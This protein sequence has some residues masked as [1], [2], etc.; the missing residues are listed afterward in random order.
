M[1]SDQSVL[2]QQLTLPGTPLMARVQPRQVTWPNVPAGAQ[3]PG[4]TGVSFRRSGGGPRTRTPVDA[5]RITF[6]V[7]GSTAAEAETTYRA[8]VDTL[9]GQLNMRVAL[10]GGASAILYLAR[11]VVVGAHQADPDTGNPF[12]QS[13][14]EIAYW[15]H[16]I[17]A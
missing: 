10:E 7:W 14:W 3:L 15:R 6:R 16:T 12:V 5:V 4:Y 8:L 1:I 9:H 2:L 13:V 11:E 17:A